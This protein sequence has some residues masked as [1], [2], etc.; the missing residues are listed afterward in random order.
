MEENKK[1][2]VLEE[3]DKTYIL[4]EIVDNRHKDKWLYVGC[5]YIEDFPDRCIEHF[6]S[7]ER[8]IDFMMEGE[9][10]ENFGIN[11]IDMI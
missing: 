8:F 2:E 9:G 7:T 10:R 6:T 4:Y 3:Q 5:C 11:V 1:Q